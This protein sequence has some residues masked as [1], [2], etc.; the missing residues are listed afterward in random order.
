MEEEGDDEGISK[1]QLDSSGRAHAPITT[2]T[3]H[4]DVGAGASAALLAGEGEGEGE[5]GQPDGGG[6]SGNGLQ[7]LGKTENEEKEAGFWAKLQAALRTTVRFPWAYWALGLYC[8]VAWTSVASFNNVAVDYIL[9]HIDPLHASDPPHS[10]SKEAGFILSI[11]F[12]AT[13]SVAPF[14]GGLITAAGY[15]TPFMLGSGVVVLLLHLFLA[16]VPALAGLVPLKA[17][18]AVL[19]LA[20]AVYAAAFWPLVPRVAASG[21]GGCAALCGLSLRDVVEGED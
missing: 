5:A 2:D 8:I 20:F 21:R 13:A 11:V 16:G 10:S 18:F 12:I 4:Q 15:S 17:L 3:L 1:A 19:G 6:G 9:R 14:V 7:P